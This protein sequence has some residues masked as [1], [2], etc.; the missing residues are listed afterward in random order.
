[1]GIG[2]GI[3]LPSI[4]YGIQVMV[5]PEDS[6][7]AIRQSE[8]AKSDASLS[9]TTYT[10]IRS[11][12]MSVGL[13]LGGALFENFMARSLR[14]NGI[15]LQ[16][17][18]N[19]EGYIS[20]LKNMDPTDQNTVNIVDGFMSGFKAVFVM[21]TVISGIGLMVFLLFLRNERHEG[22]NGQNQ[23]RQQALSTLLV[24]GPRVPLKVHTT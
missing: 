21:N 23:C 11:L 16:V 10:S 17:A 3:L 15:T 22:S 5:N 20:I 19:A 2:N 1:M 8:D 9:A 18:R 12:G 6:G 13:A 4:N 7:L 14:E 24:E